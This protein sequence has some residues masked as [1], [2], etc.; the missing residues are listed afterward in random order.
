[1]CATPLQ[2][3]AKLALSFQAAMVSVLLP[4]AARWVRRQEAR[5]LVEGVP[6]NER[7]MEIA[8]AVGVREPQ[9]VRA[10]RVLRVPSVLPAGWGWLQPLARRLLREVTGMACGHGVY[11]RSDVWHDARLWA[12]ELTHVAQYER[13]AIRG[14]VRE[15]LLQCLRAGYDA[16]PLERE[17]RQRAGAL[18]PE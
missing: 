1:M 13:L 14:F 10:R 9:R 16:S 18:F 7:Q 4:L 2:P 8:R 6:L 11:I 12:H 17:A 5:L 15:Y 3:V